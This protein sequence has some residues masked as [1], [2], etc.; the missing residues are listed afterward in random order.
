MGSPEG[1]ASI[2]K[3]ECVVDL[4]VLQVKRLSKSDD[5][6][7]KRKGARMQGRY[8]TERSD[9]SSAGAQRRALQPAG[10]RH[11]GKRNSSFE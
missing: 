10:V 7:T 4:I 5:A 1:L 11:T 2:P 8:A 3:L 9:G 6:Q